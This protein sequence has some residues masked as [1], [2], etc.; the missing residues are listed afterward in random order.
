MDKP[1]VIAERLKRL[2][3][4]LGYDKARA[5]CSYVGISDQA[6]NNY[7]SGAPPDLSR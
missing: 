3:R 2:R 7:E 6:W 4:A 5:F 1:E